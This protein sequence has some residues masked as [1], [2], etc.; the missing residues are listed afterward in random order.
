M[1][2]IMRYIISVTVSGESVYDIEAGSEAE[3]RDKARKK[4]CEEFSGAEKRVSVLSVHLICPSC[5]KALWNEM[6]Y[7]Y[8]CG[9]ARPG[10]E[11]ETNG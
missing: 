11:D 5:K 2:D 9:A 4:A 1:G 6:K 8:N 3:A 7:C 10:K